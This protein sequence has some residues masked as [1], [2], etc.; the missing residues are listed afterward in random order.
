MKKHKEEF[1][2]DPWERDWYETGSTRPPKDRG[3]LI[4][5]LLML[6]IVSGSIATALGILNVR[7]FRLLSDSQKTGTVLLSPASNT[8]VSTEPPV[9]LIANGDTIENLGLEGQ[10]VSAFDRRFYQLPEGFLVTQVEEN[11]CAQLAGIRTG[12]VI[13]AVDGTPINSIDD[14]SNAIGNIQPGQCVGLR[15]YRQQVARE[16]S[17]T[18]EIRGEEE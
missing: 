13:V 9:D 2:N 12:D 5:V 14:L 11:C 16:L 17:I 6:V 8:I 15:I 4:A 7:L 18:I 1:Y 10:T 3:G